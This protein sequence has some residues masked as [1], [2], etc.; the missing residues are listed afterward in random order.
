MVSQWMIT[1]ATCLQRVVITW[2]QVLEDKE[3]IVIVIHIVASYLY[4]TFLQD[5]LSTVTWHPLVVRLRSIGVE[6]VAHLIVLVF[7]STYDVTHSLFVSTVVVHD[8][9][10]VVK[11][12]HV[13]ILV[14][15]CTVTCWLIGVEISLREETTG[16]VFQYA[17]VTTIFFTISVCTIAVAAVEVPVT[18]DIEVS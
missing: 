4:T 12:F 2:L 18:T 1:I 16:T 5:N 6:L 9:T 3:T 17:K 11:T 15:Q 8:T 13:A 10:V 14:V 7:Y